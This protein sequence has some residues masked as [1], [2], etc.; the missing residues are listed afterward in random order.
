MIVIRAASEATVWVRVGDVLP[1]KRPS[2]PY[3]AVI[4]CGPIARPDVEKVATP[5]ELIVPVPSVVE[6]L[7]NVTVPLAF[8]APGAVTATVARK[9]RLDPTSDGLDDDATE[10]EVPALPTI[11]DSTDDVLPA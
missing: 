2:P 11:W 1:V 6:P 10:I 8:P 9:V 5:D 7:R 4:A 3:N